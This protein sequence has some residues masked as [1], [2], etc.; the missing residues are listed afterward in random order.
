ML[1][2]RL[3]LMPCP[4][5]Q[6]VGNLVWHGFLRGYDDSNPPQQTVRARRVYCSNRHQRGGCGRTFSVWC[7]TRIRRL[8]LSTSTLWRFLKEAVSGSISAASRAANGPLSDRTMHRIWQRF[9]LG[10]SKIRTALLQ[11][12]PPPALPEPPSP[13]PSP[14]PAAA[15]VLAHLQTAFPDANCPIAAFQHALGT[16]FV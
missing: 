9:L 12:C 8:S 13:S 10:Q 11:R 2:E 7:A 15:Q 1:A 3:K 5:C 16:F 6:A 14:R 4:H